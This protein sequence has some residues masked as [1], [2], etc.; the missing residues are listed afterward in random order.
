MLGTVQ[1]G[2]LGTWP[3]RLGARGPEPA[4][5]SRPGQGQAP[6]WQGQLWESLM[7][8]GPDAWM[9]RQAHLGT[10]GWANKDIAGRYGSNSGVPCPSTSTGTQR[11]QADP[12]W[13]AQGSRCAPRPLIPGGHEGSDS[14]LLTQEQDIQ[15]GLDMAILGTPPSLSLDSHPHSE[16]RNLDKAGN[17]FQW[18]KD[19]VSRKWCRDIWSSLCRTKTK[20]TPVTRR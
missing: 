16:N 9:Q 18:R 3:G 2:S 14:P 6:G 15:L 11:F 1:G 12:S 17:A 8:K 20:R 13:E 19:P 7:D 10:R 4:L 5:L